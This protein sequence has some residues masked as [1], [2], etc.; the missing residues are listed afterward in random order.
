MTDYILDF[1]LKN[2]EGLIF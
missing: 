1:S 2:W